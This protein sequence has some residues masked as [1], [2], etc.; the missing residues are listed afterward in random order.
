MSAT[1]AAS[2]RARG[3]P[4]PATAAT[5]QRPSVDG[6]ARRLSR[7]RCQPLEE[8]VT[9]TGRPASS[10]SSG[11]GRASSALGGLITTAR[12]LV[13]N[14]GASNRPSSA[15][16]CRSDR[17]TAALITGG[18]PA[19]A[20]TSRSADSRRC[21]PRTVST[22]PSSTSSHRPTGRDGDR[23]QATPELGDRDEIA[24]VHRWPPRGDR[25]AG[26]AA[27]RRGC[28]CS[29]RTGIAAP[30]AAR[31][32]GVARIAGSGSDAEAVEARSTARRSSAS[33]SAVRWS[34]G[35]VT[36]RMRPETA[37]E[38]STAATTEPGSTRPQRQVQIVGREP[39]AVDR[40]GALQ[41]DAPELRLVRRQVPQAAG[42]LTSRL[43]QASLELEDLGPH[44]SAVQAD[45]DRVGRQPTG[46]TLSSR[47]SASAGRFRSSSSSAASS[48]A[49]R[50]WAA[51]PSSANSSASRVACGSSRAAGRPDSQIRVQQDEL[52]RAPPAVVAVPAEPVT[53]SSGQPSG[54]LVPTGEQRDLGAGQIHLAEVLPAP[55]PA[56]Q[57]RGLG[58]AG[59]G[60]L[61]QPG[62][63]QH[64]GAVEVGDALL[65]V[66][67]ELH[68]LA[69]SGEGL[70]AGRPR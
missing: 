56:E 57:L 12:S 67:V 69:A 24:V 49:V 41:V 8:G 20:S 55:V 60:L 38:R 18:S 33:S 54:V 43:R 16:P 13:G 34:A 31:R 37:R 62:G 4:G 30:P 51:N 14:A 10:G 32:S 3:R 26:P 68:A 42:D 1:A 40:A 6:R 44:E 58:Q 27:A 47:A 48:R 59:V 9:V 46:P 35:G 11:Q 23:P 36:E 19:L 5:D 66:A 52:G 7:A 17:A 22:S 21:H 64:P 15:A 25:A 45:R 50:V 63:E 29:A 65:R 53:G 70:A 28:R 61:G 39:A 2:V